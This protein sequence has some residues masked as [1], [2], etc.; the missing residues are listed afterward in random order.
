MRKARLHASGE[1]SELPSG[2]RNRGGA[3]AAANPRP[4]S[5]HRRRRS[6]PRTSAPPAATHA[7]ARDVT[8]PPACGVGAGTAAQGRRP[9]KAQPAVAARSPRPAREEQ[10]GRQA[11]AAGPEPRSPARSAAVSAPARGGCP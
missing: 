3:S 10:D 7:E 5:P 11:E 1:S 8:A 4:P 6:A 2:K 9:R